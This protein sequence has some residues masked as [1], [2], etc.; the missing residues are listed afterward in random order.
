MIKQRYT[1]ISFLIAMILLFSICAQLIIPAVSV[2]AEVLLPTFNAPKKTLYVG[3]SSYQLKLENKMSSAKVTY[4]SSD[5]KVA[6]VSEQGVVTPVKKGTA[7]ITA[8]VEQEGKTYSPVITIVVKNPYITYVQKE[9]YMDAGQAFF[10]P[11]K[12]YGIRKPSITYSVSDSEV[13]SVN[14][15]GEVTA[16]AEGTITLKAEE[17]TSKASATCTIIVLTKGGATFIP[18]AGNENIPPAPN[19]PTP[20]STPTPAPTPTPVPEKEAELTWEGDYV[21]YGSYPQTEIKDSKLTKAITDASYNRD[22][23]TVK[24]IKYKRLAYDQVTNFSEVKSWKGYRYFKFEPIKWRVLE[25]K[26]NVLLPVAEKALDCAVFNFANYLKNLT[27]EDSNV[28]SWLNNAEKE[29]TVKQGFLSAAFTGN[30]LKAVIDK[31]IA[32]SDNPRYGTDAGNNTTDRAFLLSV[33]NVTNSSYGFSDDPGVKDSDRIAYLTDYSFVLGAFND[34]ENRTWWML[35]SPGENQ[36]T[37]A[38]VYGG[39]RV[40]L[41][42]V[43]NYDH[44]LGIRPAIRLNLAKVKNVK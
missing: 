6:K 14:N 32:N 15:S 9:V 8:K 39:G 38:I 43:N 30:E 44:N 40:E 12:T 41:Q 42:G 11:V 4:V 26:D 28:R 29:Y 5:T 27:W 23:A 3:Y 25:S 1:R 31:P 21:Y 36:M 35:R 22:V 13:A 16:L 33:A 19:Q 10:F 7:V 34:G 37:C 17:L 2:H 24:G 18:P 20:I